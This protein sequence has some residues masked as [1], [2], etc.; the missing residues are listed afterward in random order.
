[1]ELRRTRAAARW[2]LHAQ[3]HTLGPYDDSRVLK[4][5]EQGEL[6]PSD[7]IYSAQDGTWTVLASH[8]YFQKHG[9][10]LSF[11][12]AAHI[13]SPPSPRSLRAKVVAP[14][15]IPVM[16]PPAPRMHDPIVKK[17]AEQLPEPEPSPAAV[18]VAPEKEPPPPEDKGLLEQVHLGPEHVV[19]V[20]PIVM[21]PVHFPAIE[22]AVIAQ[23]STPAEEIYEE[24]SL[25]DMARALERALEEA[26]APVL[27]PQTTTPD[28]P[29][30]ARPEIKAVF[31]TDPGSWPQPAKAAVP[32][33]RVIQIQLKMPENGAGKAL[34][35]ALVVALAAGG[36]YLLS[37]T[38]KTRDQKGFHLSDPS[39]PIAVPLEAVDPNPP[40]KAPTR[41]QRE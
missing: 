33:A 15:P 23:P 29:I 26:P 37:N 11:R 35:F 38:N 12:R 5:L 6:L 2:F 34:L 24:E 13:P 7:K 40:L 8:P 20:E 18:I 28:S 32:S 36:G 10:L 4:G 19:H 14:P 27:Q 21:A 30:P 22:P 41:P 16:P 9:D 31:L 1:M 17:M 25:E 39:S 3:G